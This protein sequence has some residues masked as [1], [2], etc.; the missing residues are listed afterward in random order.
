VSSLIDALV[1]EFGTPLYVYDLDEV[2]RALRMLGQ[3]LVQPHL[4]HYSIKAN[5][6]PAVLDRVATKG[7]AAEVSSEGE[8]ARAR[9]AGFGAERILLTGPGK[10]ASFVAAGV[11]QGCR[12]SVESLGELDLVADTARRAGVRAQVLLRLNPP[13]R[14]AGTG[15]A[16][17][18]GPSKFGIDV[19]QLVGA[20]ARRPGVEIDGFHVFQATN[21]HDTA[22]L[23]AVLAGAVAAAREASDVLGI[24]CRLL[25]LGGGFPAPYAEPG[26]LPHLALGPE[27]GQALDAAFPHWSAGTPQVAFE[28]GRYLVGT[29]GQLLCRVVDIKVSRGLRHVI[30]DTGVHHLGG[31]SGLRRL[32]PLR[33]VPVA[34][35]GPAHAGP[36][37]RVGGPLCT[38]LDMW[39]ATPLPADLEVGDVLALP[40]VGAYGLTASLVAFLSHAPPVEV[41]L[42]DGEVVAATRLTLDDV[43]V[44]RRLTVGSTPW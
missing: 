34:P 32:A 27:L 43:D 5:P 10:A 44:P 4:I 1:D 6:H 14:Y 28:S 21:L 7:H 31:M 20:R 24:D 33:A 30:V 16:M 18:G 17:T 38:P 29:A 12:I 15:L 35:R 8:L 26:P 41:A 22:S 39:P 42:A 36:P 19:E 23:A 9:L 40:N 11:T 25:D 13:D 3:A 37:T 2:D